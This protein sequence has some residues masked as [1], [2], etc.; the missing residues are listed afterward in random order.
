MKGRIALFCILTLLTTVVLAAGSDNSKDPTQPTKEPASVQPGGSTVKMDRPADAPAP[1]K[2][3]VSAQPIP[4]RPAD[5]NATLKRAPVGEQ[6]PVQTNLSYQNTYHPAPQPA[7]DRHDYPR[8]GGNNRWREGWSNPWRRGGFRNHLNFWMVP[9]PVFLPYPVMVRYPVMVPRRTLGVY[10]LATG[11]DIVGT[12]FVSSVQNHI[13]AAGLIPV[14]TPEEATLELYT[15][16]MD[17]DPVHPGYSSAVSVSFVWFPGYRFITAQILDVEAPQV[18]DA[19]A[20]VVSYAN[21]LLH[22]SH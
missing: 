8:G 11:T 13:R 14:S 4:V 3:E 19:A 21:Q 12:D 22:Q 6:V 16:S 9:G 18:E 20:S 7:P 10:V 17:D 2:V 15:V 1:S 5:E